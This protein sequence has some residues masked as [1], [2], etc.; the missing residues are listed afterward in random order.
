MSYQ[1]KCLIKVL[2]GKIQID[3]R[4][5]KTARKRYPHFDSFNVNKKLAIRI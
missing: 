3:I 5:A 4:D 2:S 1:K